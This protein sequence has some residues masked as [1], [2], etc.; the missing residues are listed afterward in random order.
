MPLLQNKERYPS[1]L[2]FERLQRVDPQSLT[3]IRINFKIY[4][5]VVAEVGRRR[6]N[7]KV[8]FRSEL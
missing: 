5:D 4:P 1:R 7:L 6:D 2:E 8:L 3:A